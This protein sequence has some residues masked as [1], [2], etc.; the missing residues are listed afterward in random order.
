MYTQ[1]VLVSSLI[2]ASFLSAKESWDFRKKVS[3]LGL[4]NV[5][6]FK[7]KLFSDQKF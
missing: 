2:G 5:E 4:E 7:L 1:K 3:E 6:S